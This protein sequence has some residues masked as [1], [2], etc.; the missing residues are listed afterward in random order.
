MRLVPEDFRRPEWTLEVA[1]HPEAARF[2]GVQ[3]A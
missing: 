1:G 3:P 2:L